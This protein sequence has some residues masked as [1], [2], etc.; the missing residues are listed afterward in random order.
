VAFV[1]RE[2]RTAH[3]LL[4]L[5][6]F[7]SRRFSLATAA[8]L[9]AMATTGGVMFVFPFYLQELRGFAPVA[10]GAILM[11]NAAGQFAGPWSG[12]LANRYGTRAVCGAGL[13]L[14]VV[15]FGLFYLLNDV[16]PLW[17]IVA[18]LGLFGVSQGL[19]K[20]PNITMALDDVPAAGKAQ[21]GSVTSVARSLGLALGIA[22]FEVLF[23]DGIT[24]A[25]QLSGVSLETAQIPHA[26]LQHGFTLAFLFGVGL[27]IAA[28]IL[29]LRA[30]SKRASSRV[31]E[32]ALG[33]GHALRRQRTPAA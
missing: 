26:V 10:A 32:R 6:L 23:S 30:G 18:S 11:V 16:S 31:G 9:L 2:R 29:T 19:N 25:A 20:A 13:G 3:P 27:S 17:F 28:L 5:G 7:R 15:A 24:R 8:F 21:A 22:S 14:S 1:L 12:R 4:D 33:R